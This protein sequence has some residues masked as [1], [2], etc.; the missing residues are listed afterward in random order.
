MVASDKRKL[1]SS[2][3]KEISGEE[4]PNGMIKALLRV[5][6]GS[7]YCGLGGNSRMAEAIRPINVV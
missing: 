6:N 3:I 7:V 2:V 5:L 4:W 1:L